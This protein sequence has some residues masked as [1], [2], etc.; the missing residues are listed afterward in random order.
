MYINAVTNIV[1]LQLHLRHDLYNTVF[2]IKHK[3]YRVS[4]SAHTQMKT[5]G[6]HMKNIYHKP[7]THTHTHT[8]RPPSTPKQPFSD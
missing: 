6:E 3:L 4:G 7:H 2:K 5:L 1:M 8:E